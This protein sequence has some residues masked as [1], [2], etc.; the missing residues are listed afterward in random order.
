[1]EE[2]W[3]LLAPVDQVLQKSSS[4][5]NHTRRERVSIFYRRLS[6]G[7]CVFGVDVAAGVCCR[8]ENVDQVSSLLLNFAAFFFVKIWN[9]LK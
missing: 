6:T 7:S 9:K 2:K 4:K 8:G 3:L 5:S 1:M